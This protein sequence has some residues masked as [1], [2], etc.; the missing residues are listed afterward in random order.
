M[1]T[2]PPALT[3]LHTLMDYIAFLVANQNISIFKKIVVKIAKKEKPL[4]P[5]NQNV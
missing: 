5:H 1:A 4:V 2:Y 3:K